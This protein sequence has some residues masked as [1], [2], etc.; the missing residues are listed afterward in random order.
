MFSALDSVKLPAIV[1]SAPTHG[2]C[3]K[4]LW[5]FIMNQISNHHRDKQNV[6]WRLRG[7]G[8]PMN[9]GGLG[10]GMVHPVVQCVQRPC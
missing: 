1:S 5:W 3:V 2:G 8:G 7:K 4:K 9:T 6:H 10:P